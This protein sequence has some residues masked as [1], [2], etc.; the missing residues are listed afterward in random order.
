MTTLFHLPLD[1]TSRFVRLAL[2]EY[3]MEAHFEIEKVWDRRKAFLALNPA[4]TVPVLKTDEELVL[5]GANPIIGFISEGRED[6]GAPLMP[7]DAASRAEVRRLIDWALILLEGDVTSTLVHEKAMK[8]Q[9]PGKLG[10]GPPDTG[11]MRICRDNLQWHLDYTDHLIATRDWLAGE[12]ITLADLA[13]GAAYCTLDYLG[14][15]KWADHA[16][17]KA[18]YARLKSRPSFDPLLAERVSG[19]IPPNHYADPDF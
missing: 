15:I 8:R 7:S 10:G 14:E 2:A 3:E 17:T 19:V 6:R 16:P 4:A 12:R 11:A 5:V 18:W 13:F 1:V 9:I